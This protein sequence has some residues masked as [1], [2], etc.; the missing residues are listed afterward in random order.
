[1]ISNVI[2]IYLIGSS[3]TNNILYNIMC[4]YYKKAYPYSNMGTKYGH[5]RYILHNNIK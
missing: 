2:I 1:M 3:I 5:P 4:L